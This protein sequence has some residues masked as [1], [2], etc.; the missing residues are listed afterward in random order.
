MWSLKSWQTVNERGLAKT[1]KLQLYLVTLQFYVVCLHIFPFTKLHRWNFRRNKA[2]VII[3]IHSTINLFFFWEISDYATKNVPEKHYW[4]SDADGHMLKISFKIPPTAFKIH[5]HNLTFSF[6]NKKKTELSI[7]HNF[8]SYWKLNSNQ[9][10]L[11]I[12][13]FLINVSS[14]LTLWHA[15]HLFL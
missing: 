9:S 14:T 4:C 10:F 8:S 11:T 7:T 6:L 3:I 1:E 5:V 12:T 13:F 2:N 15:A